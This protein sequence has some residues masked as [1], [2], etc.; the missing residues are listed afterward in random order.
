MHIAH[1]RGQVSVILCEI[2]NSR[3]LLSANKNLKY[4]RLGL[5]DFLRLLKLPRRP[6]RQPRML[7][8]RMEMNFGEALLRQSHVIGRGAKVGQCVGRI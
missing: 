7:A 1:Q 6:Q 3:N 5:R 4:L 2:Y 8:Q